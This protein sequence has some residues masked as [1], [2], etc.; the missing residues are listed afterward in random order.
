MLPQIRRIPSQ[1]EVRSEEKAAIAERD[2]PHVRRTQNAPPGCGQPRK[3][4]SLDRVVLV[5]SANVGQFGAIHL[6][7][8]F[9]T[10]AIVH[11]K[12]QRPDEPQRSKDIENRAPAE[13][14]HDRP[15]DEGCHRHSETTEKMGGALD[16]ATLRSGKPKLHSPARYRKC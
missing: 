9:W 13:G 10:I 7:M 4:G 15:G 16:A 14:E 12:P 6:G 8:L 5:E 2:I 11:R 3:D 1:I